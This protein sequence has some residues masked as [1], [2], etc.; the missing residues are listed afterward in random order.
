MVI[1]LISAFQ[2]TRVIGMSHQPS[3]PVLNLTVL[4]APPHPELDKE[5]MTRRAAGQR[6]PRSFSWSINN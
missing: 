3:R 2:V 5:T 4:F 6:R 1:L